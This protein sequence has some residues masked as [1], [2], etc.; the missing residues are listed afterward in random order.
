M[1]FM[2][3]RIITHHDLDGIVSASLCSDYYGIDN[4]IFA[5][6]T[7]IEDKHITVSKTDIICDLPYSGSCGLWFD[8]HPGNNH[9]FKYYGINP[10]EI[11][12]HYS[13]KPSCARVILDY[14]KNASWAEYIEE[15]VRQTDLIDSFAYASKEEWEKQTTG[16][17]LNFAIMLPGETTT[18]KSDFM[19]KLVKTIIKH[20]LEEILEF[21]WVKPR[22]EEYLILEEKMIALISE[23]IIFLPQDTEKTIPIVD[24]TRHNRKPDVIRTLAFKIY[25]DAKAIILIQNSHIKNVKTNNLNISMSIGFRYFNKKHGKDIGLIMDTLGLGDG[26]KGAAGG[27]VIC[28]SKQDLLKKKQNVLNNIFDLWQQQPGIIA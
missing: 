15:T 21:D 8:H 3:K 22:I 24:M 20:S 26:H 14:L 18:D 12:G 13:L 16:K 10:K 7:Y 5:S 23:S 6:P 28:E 4:I 17:L 27:R 25:P 19:R 9:K 1:V 2:Y 11:P